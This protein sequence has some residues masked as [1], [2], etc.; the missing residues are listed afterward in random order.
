MST[1]SYW[2]FLFF[3]CLF[4]SVTIHYKIN[5]CILDGN[6]W[7]AKR[8][9][10]K[11][12]LSVVVVVVMITWWARSHSRGA[13]ETC[14]QFQWEKANVGCILT[15]MTDATERDRHQSFLQML[16]PQAACLPSN[17]TPSSS[18][19][20]HTVTIGA[21]LPANK[22]VG[23][24]HYPD[25]KHVMLLWTATRQESPVTEHSELVHIASFYWRQMVS[26]NKH[27]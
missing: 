13:C 1:N 21:K 15:P 22:P 2:S 3:K 8:L 4:E 6:F 16:S 17:L 7:K 11:W 18:L 23:D 27:V 14:E 20:S 25:R 10:L 24:K 5:K 9:K 12:P 26:P 19:P